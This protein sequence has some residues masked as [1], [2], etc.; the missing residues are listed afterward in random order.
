MKNDGFLG[1]C[2]PLIWNFIYALPAVGQPKLWFLS[3]AYALMLDFV[4]PL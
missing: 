1:N 4:G 2:G 3:F